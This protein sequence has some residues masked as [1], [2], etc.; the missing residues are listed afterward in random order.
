MSN[1]TFDILKQSV[2]HFLTSPTKGLQFLRENCTQTPKIKKDLDK[3]EVFIKTG[4]P[5]FSVWVAGNEKLPFLSFSSVSGEY[6]CRGA[7]DCLKFC[8]TFRS[9]RNFT[10]FARQIQNMLL[11]STDEG[12]AKIAESLDKHLKRRKFKN[13]IVDIR[14]YVDGDFRDQREIDQWFSILRLRPHVRAY[15]YSKSLDL[16]YKMAQENISVPFNYK[17]NLS[18]GGK[19]DYLH[20]LIM[21]IRPNWVRGR[22]AAVP[23]VKKSMKN[24]DKNDKKIMR[25]WAKEVFGKDSKSFVCPSKCGDCTK[26]G[27][28]CGLDSFNDINILIPVH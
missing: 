1:F 23:T 22:F 26:K 7:G 12:F 16:F 4:T 28:A 19:F 2:K 17:L 25:L 6:T 13:R 9:W 21:E 15:G 3:L 24:L 20:D 11:L 5:Q 14:L 10:P 27:H 18:T 8:Y